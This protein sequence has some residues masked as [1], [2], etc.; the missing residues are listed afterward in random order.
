ML[1]SSY[2]KEKLRSI[3]LMI[4]RSLQM[5]ILIPFLMI[6]PCHRMTSK[7]NLELPLEISILSSQVEVQGRRYPL[8]DHKAPKRF[9]FSPKRFGLSKSTSS[10]VY[11]I[12]ILFHTIVYQW[13]IFLLPINCHTCLFLVIFREV[14]RI[15]NGNSQWQMK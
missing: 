11:P 6:L 5:P 13:H 1:S 15:L 9:G 7:T 12:F 3:L 14:L 10:I 2:W 4:Q 8:R